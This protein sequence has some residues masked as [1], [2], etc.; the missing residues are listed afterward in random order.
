MDAL[1]VSYASSSNEEENTESIPKKKPKLDEEDI[2]KDALPLLPLAA[3]LLDFSSILDQKNVYFGNRVRS[4]PHI[5]GNYAVHVYIP[6]NISSIAKK[7]LAPL[8][9]KAGL[10]VLEL[11]V[12]DTDLPLCSSHSKSKDVAHVDVS[13]L[14]EE[15]HISLSR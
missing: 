11:H 1:K 10:L 14:A 7:E 12:I 5:E 6:V 8:M 13:P 2:S 9:K 4:F 3:A 15:Y